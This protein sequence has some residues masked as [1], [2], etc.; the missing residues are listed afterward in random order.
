VPNAAFFAPTARCLARVRLTCSACAIG[1]YLKIRDNAKMAAQPDAIDRLVESK[2]R[3]LADNGGR[4]PVMP[5][6]WEITATPRASAGSGQAIHIRF[7]IR[8]T[9]L[10]FWR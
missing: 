9:S 8:P 5:A 10:K 1:A 4:R 3:R 2:M 6:K 7:K